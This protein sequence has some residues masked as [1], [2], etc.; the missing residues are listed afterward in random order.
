MSVP[1][2][3]ALPNSRRLHPR[4]HDVYK[5]LSRLSRPSIL[6]LVLEWLDDV[7]VELC[8]P[9]VFPNEDDGNVDAPYHPAQSIQELKEIYQG[10]QARK[11][12]KREVIDRIVEGDWRNG[13]TLYQLAMA[14]TRY[15]IDHPTS[16]RWNALKLVRKGDCGNSMD[17]DP[18][19]E[20]SE[21]LPRF[22]AHTFLLNLQREISSITKAH[23]YLTQPKDLPVMLLRLFLHDSPYHTQRSLH[24]VTV[25]KQGPSDTM[26]SIFV[27]F[28]NASP[29]VYVSSP[30]AVVQHP[31]GEGRSLQRV[32]VEV[33]RL[34]VSS[35]S[36]TD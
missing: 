3:A 22:H 1:S 30:T 36:N 16:Q 35:T 34:L 25:P 32:I 13:L 5:T 7:N 28:P 2:T 24:E 8:E 4:S 6:E 18:Q 11:G 33:C 10:Y 29:H 21:R 20:E 27:V 19:S 23:Y 26:K 31:G 15:I 12:T 9:Y 14:E 17:A